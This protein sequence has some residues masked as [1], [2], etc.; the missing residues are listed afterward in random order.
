MDELL[1]KKELN[2]NKIR[3]SIDESID[4][5]LKYVNEKNELPKSNEIY[6]NKN[7][8]NIF[9]YIKSNINNNKNEIYLKLSKNEIIKKNIDEHLIK[10]SKN[11]KRLDFD[12]SLNLLIKYLSLNNNI[13][14][15]ENDIIDDYKIGKW[16]QD[17]KSKINS[18]IDERYIKLSSNEII[19][20]NI[21]NYLINKNL[22]VGKKIFTFDESLELFLKFVKDNNKIPT[23]KNKIDNNNIGSWFINQKKKINSNECDKYK[24]FSKNLIVKNNIDEY[25]K[26]KNK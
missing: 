25:L 3:L 9:Y 7:I 23:K 8:S 26:N 16:Y 11:K 15:K 21:D 5:L 4:I 10:I 19:K 13:V 6:N 1:K 14:P 22:N 24:K 20:K 12:K 18:D 2:K 17:I